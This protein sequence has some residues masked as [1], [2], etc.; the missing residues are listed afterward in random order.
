M[1]KCLGVCRDG[2]EDEDTY[3]LVRGFAPPTLLLQ[4]RSCCSSGPV[5]GLQ[6]LRDN[7]WMHA[8]LVEMCLDMFAEIADDEKKVRECVPWQAFDG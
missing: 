8:N 3:G 4:L 2:C 7:V 6:W 5:A 1:K